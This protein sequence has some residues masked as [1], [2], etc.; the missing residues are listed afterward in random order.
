[1]RG[2]GKAQPRT[3]AL[4]PRALTVGFGEGPYPIP[5]EVSLKGSVPGIAVV[6]PATPGHP[7]T[8]RIGAVGRLSALGRTSVSG[9]LRI[10]SGVEKGTLL[11]ETAKSSAILRVS[12]PAPSTTLPAGPLAFSLNGTSV[13]PPNT[14]LGS[15]PEL[16]SGTLA[17]SLATGS[18]RVP[19]TLVFR[20]R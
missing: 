8:I 19:L 11:L 18:G 20:S 16:G 15:Q 7:E 4:E 1:M 10:V 2:R 13:G 3:E 12:G 17:V 9:T 6:R 5:K 14:T